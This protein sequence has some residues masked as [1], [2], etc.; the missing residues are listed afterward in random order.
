[1]KASGKEMSSDEVFK[2]VVKD[3]VFYRNT[4]GGVTLSGG[5]P[6]AQADFSSEILERAKTEGIDTCVETAGCA[7]WTSFEK[8]LPFTDLYLF[9]VKFVDPDLHEKWT[10]F[11]NRLIQ[12]NLE[13]LASRDK[14]VIVR[15][16]LIPDVNDGD[17]FQKIMD[18]VAE[19]KTIKEVHILPFHQLG[20]SKYD[21]LGIAYSMEAHREDNRDGIERCEAHAMRRGFRVSIGGS[22]FLKG[23]TF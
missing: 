22:G 5:E 2:E 3:R 16:P 15:I 7:P 1:L 4:G 19:L 12:E 21:Q 9:D 11:R 14:E 8:T 18:R 17:E 20:S 23:K 13:T 10:G 6:L